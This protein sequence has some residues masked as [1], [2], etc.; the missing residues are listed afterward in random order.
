MRILVLGCGYVGLALAEAL[1]RRGHEVT[2]IR[3]SEWRAPVPIRSLQ[4]DITSPESL[5]RLPCDFEW[6]IH[7]A[8]ASEGGPSDYRSVYL[9]GN[10]NLL[11]WLRQ[12]CSHTCVK[13]IYTSSTAVYAQDDGST[14]TEESPTEPT[15][16][17]GRI[18]VEAERVVVDAAA[19]G[20][21]AVLLRVAGIYGPGRG[22]WLRQFLSGDARLQGDGHRVLNMVHR[23]DVAGAIIHLLERAP[24]GQIYNVADSDS[25][26]QIQV[27]EWL[28]RYLG[29]SLPAAAPPGTATDRRTASN[30]RVSSQKLLTQAGYRLIYPT[31]REGYAV[32]LARLGH[33]PAMNE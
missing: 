29:R 11:S 28:A 10:R 9:K 14:V 5:A 20:F 32:E 3:R 16:E 21:P 26:T 6:V 33:R 24:G 19:A 27:F 18:L 12:A 13:Y 30:K 4:A 17:T 25:P 1:A 15:T 23:D 31:F 7:C 22:Y 8:A 2:G